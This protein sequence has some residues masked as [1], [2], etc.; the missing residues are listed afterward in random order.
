MTRDPKTVVVVE[1]EFL[2]RM[3]AVEILTDAGFAVIEAEDAEAAL[4]SLQNPALDIRLVFTDIHMP[5][6]MNGLELAHHIRSH[7]PH[8]ALLI[9]SGKERP[10]PAKL[11][12]E[13]VFLEKPYHPDRVVAHVRTLTAA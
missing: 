5:G 13:S 10:P 3:L 4:V 8:I 2:V 12:A 11:P 1:D 9:A 7:W 6:S